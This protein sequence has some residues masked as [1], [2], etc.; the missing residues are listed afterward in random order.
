MLRIKPRVSYRLNTQF[1]TKL[2]H[3]YPGFYSWGRPIHLNPLAL[4]LKDRGKH[5]YPVLSILST[6]T[7]TAWAWPGPGLLE[8]HPLLSHRKAQSSLYVGSLPRAH[9]LTHTNTHTRRVIISIQ[10]EFI[11]YPL[12]LILGRGTAVP[13]GVQD[14]PA[15][16][17]NP[18]EPKT[19]ICSPSLSPASLSPSWPPPR[20]LTMLLW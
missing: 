20:L 14:L 17:S 3:P 1:I 5:F 9:L 2:Q 6:N 10:S 8:D 19:S 18:R 16:N 12:D 4:E 15:S 13:P 11:L 7:I